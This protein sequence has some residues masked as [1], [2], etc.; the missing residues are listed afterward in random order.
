[1]TT[2]AEFFV[3][4]DT[5]GSRIILRLQD[6][7]GIVSLSFDEEGAITLAEELAAGIKQIMI[8]EMGAEKYEEL[9]H[10]VLGRVRD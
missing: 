1:M 4:V 10:E 6:E 9:R 3:D 8:Q 5:H 7:T 2:N